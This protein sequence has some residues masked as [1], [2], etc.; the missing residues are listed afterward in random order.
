MN[1]YFKY[2][3]LEMAEH[4]CGGLLAEECTGGWQVD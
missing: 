3:S 4:S 2:E 1:N